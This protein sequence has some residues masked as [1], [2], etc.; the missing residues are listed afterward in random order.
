M[1]PHIKARL[2]AK[3]TALFDTERLLVID[4]PEIFKLQSVQVVFSH[5]AKDSPSF[6]IN[7]LA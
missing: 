7:D 2:V 3:L 5:D 4:V 6:A 1:R